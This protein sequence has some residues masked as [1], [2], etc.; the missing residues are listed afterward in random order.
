MS[1]FQFRRSL[2]FDTPVFGEIMGCLNSKPA[3]APQ[4]NPHVA[5]DEPSQTPRAHVDVMTPPT[6]SMFDSHPHRFRN[7]SPFFPSQTL[8]K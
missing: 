8:A 1:G 2:N 5:T 7:H 3:P 6:V 4:S